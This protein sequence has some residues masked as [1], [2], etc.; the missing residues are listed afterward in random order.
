MRADSGVF[1]AARALLATLSLAGLIIA[2]GGCAQVSLAWASFD[3]TG[4]SATPPVLG[5]FEGAAPVETVAQWEESRAPALRE[6]FQ[7]HIYGYY[8]DASETRVLEQRTLDAAAFDGAGLLEEYSLQISATFDDEA[9]DADVFRMDLLLPVNAAG[10]VPVVLIQTFC[11][12]PE[13]T[14]RPAVS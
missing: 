9:V 6:A 13:E 8:P 12:L 1:A 11:P 4:P 2:P 14:T 7:R 3:V 10:P 5:A